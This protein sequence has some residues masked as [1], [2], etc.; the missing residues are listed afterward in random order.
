MKDLIV[1]HALNKC[2]E[3]NLLSNYRQL[4]SIYELHSSR[5]NQVIAKYIL[6]KFELVG[7]LPENIYN[8]LSLNQNKLN[9]KSF[10][11]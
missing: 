4:S 10:V 2:T 1:L 6:Q 7:I 3:S 5:K 11:I 8:L 9:W